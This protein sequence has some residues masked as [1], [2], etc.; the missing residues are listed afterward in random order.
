M[1]KVDIT[2]RNR[3]Y[4]ISCDDNQEEHV[5]FLAGRLSK[6]IDIL[7][8]QLGTSNDYMYLLM[9]ALMLEDR[10]YE[11]E[12]HLHASDES[13]HALESAYHTNAEAIKAEAAGEANETLAQ[14]ISGI[15][16]YIETIAKKLETV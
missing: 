4:A 1:P 2:I 3:T 11:M 14:S 16:D 8:T 15:A 5:R 6:R 13:K 7:A 9:T 12:K 10:V